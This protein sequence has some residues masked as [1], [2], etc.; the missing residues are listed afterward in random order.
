M[1]NNEHSAENLSWWIGVQKEMKQSAQEHLASLEK[2]AARNARASS[3]GTAVPWLNDAITRQRDAIDNIGKS[4]TAAEG[5]LGLASTDQLH[6]PRR[7]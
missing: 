6:D 4:I 1:T 2:L 3:N 5:Y 7:G